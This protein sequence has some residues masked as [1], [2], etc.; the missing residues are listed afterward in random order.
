LLV[1]LGFSGL[2]LVVLGYSACW[3][4]STVMSWP[5]LARFSRPCSAMACVRV[6]K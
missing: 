5:P 4:R 6:G 2:F 1:I 3:V